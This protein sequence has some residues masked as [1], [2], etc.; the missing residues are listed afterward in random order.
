MSDADLQAE[1]QAEDWAHREIEELAEVIAVSLDPSWSFAT[2]EDGEPVG[3]QV[4][5]H[6]WA[7]AEAVLRRGY[8]RQPAL[9]FGLKPTTE[10]GEDAPF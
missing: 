7:A 6:A 9:D 3:I 4:W 2:D 5:H 8:R 10:G 1:M